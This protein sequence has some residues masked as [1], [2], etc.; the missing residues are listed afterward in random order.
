MSV[1]DGLNLVLLTQIFSKEIDLD[2][3]T[4]IKMHPTCVKGYYT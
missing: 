4:D 2:K 1:F 3:F